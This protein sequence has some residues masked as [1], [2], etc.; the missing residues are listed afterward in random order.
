MIRGKKASHVLAFFL[1]AVCSG[2]A[3]TPPAGSRAGEFSSA[4]ELIDTPFYPQERYQCGPAALMT[5]LTA[6]DVETS[7]ENLVRQVYIPA[8]EGSLQA[9]MLAAT[10][11]A[12]RIPYRIDGNLAALSSELQ[13]GRPVLVLQNLG[14]R[15]LPRWHYAVVVGLDTE[16]D[17]IVLRSGTE[18][19]RVTRLRTFL[20]TWKRS[21]NWGFVTLK[22]N[23]LPVAVNRERWFRALAALEQTGP[24]DASLMAW[25]QAAARWPDSAVAVFGLGNGYLANGDWQLAETQYRQLLLIEPGLALASNNLALALMQQG[26]FDEALTEATRARGQVEADSALRAEIEKTLEEIRSAQSRS[27]RPSST[28]R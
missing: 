12:G 14:V 26:R 4:S 11:A 13:A 22:P 21:G 2:C 23:E 18:S 8:Q 6:S 25:R 28:N 5:V 1:L 10:R 19:R 17:H 9:E 15:F 16:D 7:V 3:Y 27:G 24:N 20:H